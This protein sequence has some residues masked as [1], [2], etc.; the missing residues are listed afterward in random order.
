[1]F[2]LTVTAPPIRDFLFKTFVDICATIVIVEDASTHKSAIAH[3]GTAFCASWLLTFWPKINEFPGLIVEYVYVK[4]GDPSYIAF[5]DIVSRNRQTNTQT[6]LKNL[7]IRLPLEWVITIKN[8]KQSKENWATKY[9]KVMK[10]KFY[11][12]MYLH[13]VV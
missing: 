5:W 2:N 7:P 13:T 10:L 3:A 11:T 12:Y 8:G 4:F 1:M 9:I 6:P